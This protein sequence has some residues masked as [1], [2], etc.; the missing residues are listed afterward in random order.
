MLLLEELTEQKIED[1]LGIA[2]G[3]IPFKTLA[4]MFRGN[5]KPVLRPDGRPL[6]L[7]YTHAAAYTAHILEMFGMPDAKET[8]D[9]I[10]LPVPFWRSTAVHMLTKD[11]NAIFGR[12]IQES[13]ATRVAKASLG[14]L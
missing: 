9:V 12:R 13:N 6:A 1:A 11:A 10:H 7:S 5:G 4:P 2:S 8:K 3:V 14:V